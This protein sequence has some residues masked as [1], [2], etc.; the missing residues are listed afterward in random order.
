MHGSAGGYSPYPGS[1]PSNYTN[2]NFLGNKRTATVPSKEPA[3]VVN[4]KAAATSN[5]WLLAPAIVGTGAY[6]FFAFIS[7]DEAECG[8]LEKSVQGRLGSII[9]SCIATA[10]LSSYIYN[11]LVATDGHLLN[12]FLPASSAVAAQILYFAA[13]YT[14]LY[15]L[16]SKSFS[17]KVD[18]K[19]LIDEIV[20]FIYFS[21]TT[22]A[23][24]GGD[25]SP[26]TITARILVSLQVLF[27][28]YTFTM[29]MVFFASP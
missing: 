12:V 19:N 15:R 14:W 20:A 9:Y 5:V 22:F 3:Y 16:D 18:K 11:V 24:A 17:V 26:Q 7:S 21:I 8:E 10:G 29:G 25:I 28:I 2:P 4:G 27:F 13:V 23:T 1:Y 6:Y